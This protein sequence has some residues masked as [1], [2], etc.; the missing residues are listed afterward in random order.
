MS[1][2]TE[3]LVFPL[4]QRSNALVLEA[5]SAIAS[6]GCSR[7]LFGIAHGCPAKM[8]ARIGMFGIIW[9]RENLFRAVASAQ[10]DWLLCSFV[11]TSKPGRASSSWLLR[12]G[13]VIHQ[14]AHATHSVI[15]CVCLTFRYASCYLDTVGTILVL[16]FFNLL[17]VNFVS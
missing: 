11:P 10:D 3:L 4:T 2:S 14:V 5:L 17:R 12:S 16:Q 13:I 7:R 8:L 6:A 1:K 9:I 15:A